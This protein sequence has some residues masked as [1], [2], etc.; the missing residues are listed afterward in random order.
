MYYVKY[1]SHDILIVLTE[2]VLLDIDKYDLFSSIKKRYR[3]STFPL[4]CP[5]WKWWS[6]KCWYFS[7][8]ICITRMCF[9]WRSWVIMMAVA[10]M[11]FPSY[12]VSPIV[13]F[14]TQISYYKQGFSCQYLFLWIFN[15]NALRYINHLHV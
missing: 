11:L 13:N 12:K 3:S 5:H 9:Q 10:M 8:T 6:R 1:L 2:K 7:P 14:H 15:Q 4:T